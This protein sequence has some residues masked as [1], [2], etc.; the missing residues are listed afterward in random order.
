M[1]VSGCWTVGQGKKGALEDP[2][3]G[4]RNHCDKTGKLT[5]GLE[6]GACMS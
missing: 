1:A 4:G 5:V 2:K 6:K 3:A